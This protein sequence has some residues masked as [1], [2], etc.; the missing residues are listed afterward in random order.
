MYF[1][2]FQSLSNAMCRVSFNTDAKLRAW[3]NKSFESEPCVSFRIDIEN[4]V[5]LWEEVVNNKGGY[6][7]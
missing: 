6:I 3:L 5:Q 1:H 7:D 2:L 4:F